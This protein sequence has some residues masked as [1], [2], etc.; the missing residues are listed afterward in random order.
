LAAV[1]VEAA[2]SASIAAITSG[3]GTVLCICRKQS[4]D[5]WMVVDAIDSIDCINRFT[6]ARRGGAGKE[7][8]RGGGVGRGGSRGSRSTI[9]KQQVGLGSRS[10]ADGGGGDEGRD[11]G[12]GT[13]R[14][15]QQQ[16]QRG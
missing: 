1:A 9:G 13:E 6:F 4:I 8:G 2:S 14:G 16:E 15:Y 10:L 7:G 12:D 3:L 11:G 5:Q